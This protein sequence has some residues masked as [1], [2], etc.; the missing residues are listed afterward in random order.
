MNPTSRAHTGH[1]GTVDLLAQ[2]LDGTNDLRGA[3][4]ACAGASALFEPSPMSEPQQHRFRRRAA[5]LALCDEC[6]LLPDCRRWLASEPRTRWVGWT[7]AGQ[8][9]TADAS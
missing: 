8:L 3:R 4:A 7:V 1:D 2:I 9:I 6:P 5:A